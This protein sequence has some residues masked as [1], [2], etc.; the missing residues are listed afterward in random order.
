MEELIDYYNKWGRKLLVF[1]IPCWIFLAFIFSFISEEVSELITELVNNPSI[2]YINQAN[3][4]KIEQMFS[5]VVDFFAPTTIVAALYFTI[6]N[7]IDHKGWKIKFPQYDVSGEWL[8]ITKYTKKLDHCGWA[9]LDQ[10]GVPSPVRIKQTCHIIEILPSTGDKF[11]WHSLS[12][13]WDKNN[14]LKI[15]Y[16][17]EYYGGLQRHGYPERRIGYESMRICTTGLLAGK[18]PNKMV[19]KFWQCINDDNKPVYMGDVVYER[20]MDEIYL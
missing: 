8:D 4:Q 19:G 14:N 18:R 3:E 6:L 7:Y 9:S 1:S 13:N 12:A 2:K 10:A 17:V 15:L 11:T 20:K 5:L 16:E